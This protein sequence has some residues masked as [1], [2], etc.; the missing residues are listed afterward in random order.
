MHRKYATTVGIGL[1][2]YSHVPSNAFLL[3][4]SHAEITEIQNGL[5][6]SESVW[7]TYEKL[8]GELEGISKAISSLNKRR[9]KAG[10][11]ANEA[12]NDSEDDDIE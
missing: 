1:R 7:K 3:L 9:G 11:T 6:V 5:R 12:E 8:S 10:G 4:L 2:R